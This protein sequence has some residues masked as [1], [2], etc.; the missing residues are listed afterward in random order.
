LFSR[1]KFKWSFSGGLGKLRPCTKEPR[2]YHPRVTA[3]SQPDFLADKSAVQL[4]TELEG[5]AGDEIIRSM[6]DSPGTANNLLRCAELLA[7][8]SDEQAGRLY[9]HAAFAQ[10]KYKFS[11]LAMTFA[12]ARDSLSCIDALTLARS[13]T[14]LGD[15]RDAKSVLDDFQARNGR[16]P[17]VDIEIALIL[18]AL[19][20]T[21][22]ALDQMLKLTPES[23][24]GEK[25]PDFRMRNWL[26]TYL[27]ST[28]GKASGGDVI[29]QRALA[30]RYVNTAAASDADVV[31]A[32]LDYKSPEF[33][34]TSMN[35]GDYV[36]TV[37]MMRHLARRLDASTTFDDPGL[38]APFAALRKSWPQASR[39]TTNNK[40]HLT[41]LDRDVL[42]P[43][44]TLH[45]QRVIWT[46]F[47][48]WYFHQPFR[49]GGPF[50]CPENINPLILSFYL[51]RPEDLD[52]PTLDYLKRHGPVGCRDWSTVY[53]LLNQG[54]D[55]FFSGCLTLTLDLP[56]TGER[57]G[58]VVV[59]AEDS[60]PGKNAESVEHNIP[61]HRRLQFCDAIQTALD[62]LQRYAG[63]EHVKTSRLHC[64]LPCRALG[65]PVTFVPG[66]F[67][68]RR[69]D[70][71]D[72]PDPCSALM[73]RER[74][75]RILDAVLDKILQGRDV[76][77]VREAW[78]T[79]TSPLVAEARVRMMKKPHLL[80]A[81]PDTAIHRSSIAA[82]SAERTIVALA[83]DENVL[84]YA[85]VTIRSILANTSS[86]VEFV[87][88]TRGISMAEIDKIKAEFSQAEFRVIAMDTYLEAQHAILARNTTVSTMDRLYLPE[89]LPDTDKI[90]Y[91]DIDTII[92]GDIAELAGYETSARGIA[93]RST[94]NPRNNRQVHWIERSIKLRSYTVEK[95]RE[96]RRRTAAALDLLS[97]Y[98]N[99]GVL[100]LSLERLRALDATSEMLQLVKDYGLEDQEA[101]NLFSCGD[102]NR[103]PMEWNA[104]PYTD[105]FDHAKLIHWPGDL[106]PWKKKRNIRH[107]GQWWKY[108]LP[109]TKE[110]SKEHWA[111]AESYQ[112]GW[113]KR[114]ILAARW[115][116]NL[117]R[118]ADIGCGEP[119]SLK[120]HLSR[121]TEYIPADLQAWTPDVMVIDLDKREFPSGR[122]DAVAMLGV[123]E[124]LQRP[125]AALRRARKGS[126]H[127]VTSYCHPVGD[128]PEKKREQRGW[129]NAFSETRFES[130]LNRQGWAIKER[131]LYTENDSI[132]QFVYHCIACEPQ[133]SSKSGV[134]DDQGLR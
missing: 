22:A 43:A 56:S 86:A 69:F 127:L 96:Y 76:E 111:K 36:Q 85:V 30:S 33:K 72:D 17:E 15:F 117:D 32:V 23:D 35:I 95:A 123:L 87:L 84:K 40:V 55:A 12:R 37:A 113:E 66:D 103:L 9:A 48:G 5:P 25:S 83:F 38:A 27:Q 112:A 92:S 16:L 31:F 50:P 47:H 58:V 119:M 94:P 46:I 75:M 8:E 132:R 24:T 42:W 90:V 120:R 7:G 73:I 54:V 121:K 52:Q 109:E 3:M 106:K 131:E 18:L 29:S 26:T 114:A 70:G 78:V 2:I 67:S 99:A 105:W 77:V 97:P 4:L 13:K 14:A 122:F 68:D 11:V 129:I 28:Q 80:L 91:V 110:G 39:T 1:K 101:L 115:L 100:V 125:G 82:P 57:S 102:Y 61:H 128:N 81:D 130:L 10:K 71:L 6:L 79:V 126:K 34:K 89:L 49:Q 45:G 63:A 116:Q 93:A 41:I 65:T 98:F 62:L 107:A 108:A 133:P 21:R 44:S 51:Q 53:W 64:Y 60:V 124:Y 134:L 104:Q 88:L 118:V 20:D 19:G 74:I 59:D